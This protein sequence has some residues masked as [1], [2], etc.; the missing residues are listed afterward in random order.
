MP[1]ALPANCYKFSMG[2]RLGDQSWSENYYAYGS[3]LTAAVSAGQD[4]LEKRQDLLCAD[5]TVLFGRVSV[6]DLVNKKSTK[7]VPI[8]NNFG[9]GGFGN[10]STD[11]SMPVDV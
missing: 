3:S 2:F 7:Y 11:K 1:L 8:N 9:F 6:G 4:I 5:C 10:A